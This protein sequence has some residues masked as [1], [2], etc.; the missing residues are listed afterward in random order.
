MTLLT[1]NTGVKAR[2]WEARPL[3]VKPSHRFPGLLRVARRTLR[4]KLAS[5]RVCMARRAIGPQTKKGSIEILDQDSGLPAGIDLRAVMA[6]IALQRPMLSF[7]AITG[8]CVIEAGPARRRPP[9]QVEV[10]THVFGVTGS[11]SR[12]AL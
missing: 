3:V 12:V 11:A 6:L 7:E 8:L 9:Y 10:A 5:V 1:G 4:A 2:Q